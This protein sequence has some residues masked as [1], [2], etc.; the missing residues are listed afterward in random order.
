MGEPRGFGLGALTVR[1][2][3]DKA[4]GSSPPSVGEVGVAEGSIASERPASLVL[5]KTRA[6]AQLSISSRV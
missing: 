5:E 3:E 2:P 6:P 4:N 1:A